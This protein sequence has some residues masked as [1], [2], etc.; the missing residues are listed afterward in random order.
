MKGWLRS[1]KIKQTHCALN[2]DYDPIRMNYINEIFNSIIDMSKIIVGRCKYFEELIDGH[3]QVLFV[4]F[5]FGKVYVLNG[6]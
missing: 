1:S 3:F 6:S 5:E 4:E 2:V